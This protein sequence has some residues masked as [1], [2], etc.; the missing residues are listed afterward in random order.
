MLPGHRG[1]LPHTCA[2]HRPGRGY[3]QGGPPDHPERHHRHDPARRHDGPLDVDHAGARLP[4]T[5]AARRR[6]STRC[7]S[8]CSPA[9]WRRSPMPLV[10]ALRAPVTLTSMPRM[11]DFATTVESAA[12]RSDGKPG[13]FLKVYAERR[14]AAIDILLDN[15]LVAVWAGS[16]ARAAPA[17]AKTNDATGKARRRNCAR[18]SKL[19]PDQKKTRKAAENRQGHHRRAAARRTWTTRETRQRAVAHEAGN[20]GTIDAGNE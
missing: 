19:M 14:V 10:Q 8:T 5:T 1:R 4:I 6:M 12:P 18:R 16:T 3:F 13:E 11:A 2:A 20:G 7:F 9:S 15:D 17:D